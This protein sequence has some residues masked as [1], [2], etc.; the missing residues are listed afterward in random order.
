M[1]KLEHKKKPD[2]DRLS[3]SVQVM[4]KGNE[5]KNLCRLQRESAFPTISAYVRSLVLADQ[6]GKR[7]T[8]LLP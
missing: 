1:A 3:N 8:E 7:Q 6:K 4:L 5:Y 2:Y